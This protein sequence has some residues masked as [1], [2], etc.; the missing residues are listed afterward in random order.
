[1][2]KRGWYI[3]SRTPSAWQFIF[4]STLFC[5]SFTVYIY[6]RLL[7]INPFV[8]QLAIRPHRPFIPSDGL[9][10]TIY[11]SQSIAV[12][13]PPPPPPI[14][15]IPPPPDASPTIYQMSLRPG[16]AQ[17]DTMFNCIVQ[18]GSK[19]EIIMLLYIYIIYGTVFRYC[20][21]KACMY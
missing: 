15:V 16:L 12:I 20:T 3:F 6:I 9:W 2:P 19:V 4:Y 21:S 1:M 8:R 18:G 5:V 7:N 10:W 14:A 11:D 13:P 17:S